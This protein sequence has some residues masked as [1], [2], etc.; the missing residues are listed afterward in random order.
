MKKIT[1]KQI[2][3]AGILLG[4][5]VL[6]QIFKNISVFITGPIVNTIL[7][8]ATLTLGL[9]VGIILSII[10]PFTSLLISH[11]PLMWAL[12]PWLSLAI[13]IGNIILCVTTYVIYKRLKRNQALSLPI[14]MAVGCILKAAFMGGVISNCLLVYTKAVQNLKPEALAAAKVTFSGTQLITALIGSAIAYVIW[15]S[16]GKYLKSLSE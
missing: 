7:I 15:L 16:A 5:M 2:V 14:G 1:T 11:A 9:W 13:A 4:L 12:F 6:S 8:I 3:T 10:A